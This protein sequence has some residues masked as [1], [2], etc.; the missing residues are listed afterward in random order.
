[1]RLF[2]AVCFRREFVDAVLDY[3]NR[4]KAYGKAN[5][6][7]PENIHLTLAFIGEQKDAEPVIDA[8]KSVEFDPYPIKLSGSVRFGSIRCVGVEDGGQSVA[9]AKSVRSALDGAGIGY[10]RKPMKPHITVARE[11]HAEIPEIPVSPVCDTVSSFCLM[12]SERLNGKL[13]YTKLREYPGS[14]K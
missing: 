14:I 3:Q 4:L 1:M 10:D 8:L 7:R 2:V 9:L 6:S 5:Y 13:V 12:K 11:F